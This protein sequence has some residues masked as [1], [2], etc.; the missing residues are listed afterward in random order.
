MIG[1]PAGGVPKGLQ[2]VVLK[3]EPAI[4]ARPG[5]LLPSEDFDAIKEHIKN[6]LGIEN[7][8]QRQALKLCPISKGI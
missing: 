7:P 3:G 8:T 2:E 4:T 1:Q 6:D 5:S